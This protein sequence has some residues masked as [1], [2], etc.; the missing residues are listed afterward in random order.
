[1]LAAGLLLAPLAV[2]SAA[3]SPEDQLEQ[4]NAELDA[5]REWLAESGAREKSLVD[6]IAASD[7]RRAGVAAR[8]EDLE[9]ELAGA[10]ARLAPVQAALDSAVA[11]HERL[12]VEVAE[13]RD[14]LDR[15]QAVLDAHAAT[16]Y[17]FG[18]GSYLDVILGASSFGELIDRTALATRVL[19]F[20]SDLV[21]ELDATRARLAE[22]RAMARESRETVEARRDDL[23]AER[24]RIRR[25]KE[26]QEAA[27]AA[28]DLEIAIRGAALEDIESSR[29]EYR[30]SI[31]QL[32]ADAAQ[33]TAILQGGGSIG[34][35]DYGGELYWP[36]AG[37]IGSGYGWR[38]HPVYGDQRFHAGV[39]IGG[40]CGQP[41][42]A[43]ES[44]T[45]V[46][47]TWSGGYGLFTVVDHGDG[48]ATAY[49]HQSQNYVSAGQRVAR[50][51]TIGAVGTTG[52]STG[53]HLHF[54]VRVNGEPVDPVPYL[55]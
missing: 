4:I 28:L 25:L 6:Q 51:Q 15:Q 36:T 8:L 27:Q 3:H 19:M 42:W 22:R 10:E 38:T 40:A 35:G 47:S 7:H 5:K 2:P 13:T 16:S 33:I 39:D 17:K 34:D 24:N 21:T 54:E 49:A 18:P 50:G 12:K 46:S 55:T 20:D 30:A 41:I 32:E 37:S 14:E 23:R 9:A 29:A 43:A 31:A 44:G 26:E 11:R 53:C 52:L 45:V 1:M 48:L